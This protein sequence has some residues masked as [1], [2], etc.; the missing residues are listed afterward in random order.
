MIRAAFFKLLLNIPGL[1]DGLDN[2][3]LYDDSAIFYDLQIGHF[4]TL[5]GAKPAAGYELLS[6]FNQHVS[7]HDF[8][9]FHQSPGQL[10]ALLPDASLQHLLH[11][12]I[13]QAQIIRGR[14][15]ERLQGNQADDFTADNI[16]AVTAGFDF[17]EFKD[18]V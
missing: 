17:D 1:A 13:L 12:K 4:F 11:R 14:I 18:A 10:S 16:D 15:D 2:A 3:F 9:F 8:S 7:V 6:I 5:F